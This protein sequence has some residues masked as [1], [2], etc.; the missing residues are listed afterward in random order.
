M[1]DNDVNP[2]K[3]RHLIPPG[4][5]FNFVSKFKLSVFLSCLAMAIGI[6]SLFVNKATRG[7]YMNWTIDFKGGTEIVYS[8]TDDKG[9]YLKPDLHAAREALKGEGD[10]DVSDMRWH[11][12]KANVDVDGLIVRAARYGATTPDQQAAALKAV[13]AA[14][15]DDQLQSAYWS[16]DNLI[17]RSGKPIDRAVA[18]KAIETAVPALKVRDS[19]DASVDTSAGAPT[20]AQKSAGES[21]ITTTTIAVWGLDKQYLDSMEKAMPGNHIR[22]VNSYGVGEK[23]GGKLRNDAAK[24]L[25]YA[26]FLIMLYLAF[27]FDIRYAPGAAFATIHDAVMVVGVFSITWTEVSLTSVAAVLTVIGYSVNDTVIVFDRIRENQAKLKDKKLE[28]I[29][30]ISINEMLVRTVLTSM[31]VFVVTLAMNILGDGLIR[32]FAFA[33]NIGVIVGTYSSIFLAAPLFLWVSKKWYSGAPSG[34]NRN[35]RAA[36]VAA[37]P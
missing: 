13:Q 5:S 33:M 15:K 31:T 7:S 36:A 20:E 1:A 8:F 30:D 24:S 21:K 22:V 16:S 27:R 34:P 25:I 4:S 35:A 28:R 17:V 11:D 32:N 12:D 6:G 18:K 26:I 23:A 9:K 14:L 3:F 37:E 29:I 2:H 10:I 19:D